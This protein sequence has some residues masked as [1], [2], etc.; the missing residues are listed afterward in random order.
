MAPPNK[1]EVLSPRKKERM[2]TGKVAVS[3]FIM[4]VEQPGHSIITENLC[5]LT[6]AFKL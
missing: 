6:S 4:C 3:V 5:L 1:I 2:A